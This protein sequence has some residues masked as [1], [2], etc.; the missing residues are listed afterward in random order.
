MIE[1]KIPHD[2]QRFSYYDFYD[3][4]IGD[5]SGEANCLLNVSRFVLNPI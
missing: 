2:T 3:W 1:T 5:F 4:R